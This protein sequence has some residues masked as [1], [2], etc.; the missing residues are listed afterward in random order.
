MGE[1]KRKILD[2]NVS[3]LFSQSEGTYAR[4]LHQAHELSSILQTESDID[5]AYGIISDEYERVREIEKWAAFRWLRALSEVIYDSL[6][7]SAVHE[8]LRSLFSSSEDTDSRAV[9]KISYMRNKFTEKAFD[10]FAKVIDDAK[11][12]HADSFEGSCMDVYNGI[13]EYCILPTE[14]SSDGKLSAFYKLIEKYDLHIAASTVIQDEE[15]STI[16]SLLSRD[17]DFLKFGDTAKS[18][19]LEIGMTCADTS[20]IEGIISFATAYGLFLSRIDSK[21][22]GDGLTFTLLFSADGVQI[23]SIE[24]LTLCLS[25]IYPTFTVMGFYKHIN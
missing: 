16:V 18:R 15:T 24:I 10:K 25:S 22:S 19:M 17:I 23:R 2:A 21:K 6:D 8:H 11:L 13:C 3:R 9:G 12:S 5:S 20:D 7:P 1:E 4:F 14:N